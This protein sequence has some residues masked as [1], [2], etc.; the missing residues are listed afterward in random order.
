MLFIN[1][2]HTLHSTLQQERDRFPLWVPVLLGTGIGLYFA[3]PYEPRYWQPLSALG[4]IGSMM[5]LSRRQRALRTVVMAALLIA[6]GFSA[7]YWRTQNVAAPVLHKT[8]YFRD[9]EGRIDDIRMKPEGETLLLSSP[10]IGDVRPQATPARVSVSLHEVGPELHIGDAVRV[11]ATLFPPP[12]PALPG[13][14]DFARAFY[15]DRIGAVGFSRDV[16]EVTAPAAIDS[17]DVWLNALRLRLSEQIQSGMAAENGPVAS[18]MMVG[19]DSEVSGEVKDAMRDAGIYHVL[20]ISGLHMSLAV[21]LV[22]IT[23][24]FL[25]SLHMPLALR[26]P[27]KKIAAFVGL[28]SAFA[29]LLLAGYPVPA[30]RSFVMVAC[31]MVAVLFDRRGISLYSL[32]WAASLILLFEPESLLG[33]SFELSFAATL[34]ILAL[35]ERYAYLL[36]P[37]GRG[38]FHTVWIYFLGLIITSLAATLATTPLVIY[39]FNRF[40]FW[41]IAANVLMV[42]LA[43]FWIMPAAVLAFLAMPFGLENGPLWL[44]DRGIG[45][46]IDGSKWFASLPFA[47]FALPSPNFAGFLLIVYGGLWLCLWRERWRLFGIPAVVIG[48]ATL[49]LYEPY[50]LLVSDDASKVMARMDNGDYLFI[51]GRPTS[52]DGQVW[53]R[54]AGRESALTLKDMDIVCDQDPCLVHLRGKSL[55]VIRRKDS[56]ESTCSVPADIAITPNWLKEDACPQ[57]PLLMEKNFLEENGATGLRFTQGG[58]VMDTAI[59]HRGRRPWVSLPYSLYVKEKK[60]SISPSSPESSLRF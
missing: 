9:V 51:Q 55:A 44:L 60:G 7:A 2:L 29:Y 40:S 57:I 17:F 41:G 35:Y 48:V 26:L 47:N 52:F 5:L 12:T 8:L 15:Y 22:Y 16:P 39:H 10:S 19:E 3:L 11:K 58:I 32:A 59:E 34:A 20:S 14:Y 25:L 21:A 42:P 38:I 13:G 49:L 43:S 27:V 23:V 36:H 33:A 18:A 45:L 46:M 1:T 53:L 24:R 28:L 4:L 37:S 31:V 54:A 56:G 50:D 6:V 30:I